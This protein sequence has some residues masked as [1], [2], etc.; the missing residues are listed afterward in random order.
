[1]VLPAERLEA[2][3]RTCPSPRSASSSRVTLPTAPVA[4]TTPIRG[5]AMLALRFRALE[6]ECGMQRLDGLLD[7]SACDEA[8]DL[9]RRRSDDHR[10]NPELLERGEH[11]RGHSGVAPHPGADHAD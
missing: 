6:L 4:P 3:A 5:S 9:D 8:A 1:T 7:L 11:L 10:L 2:K